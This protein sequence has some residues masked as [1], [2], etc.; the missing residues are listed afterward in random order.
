MMTLFNRQRQLLSLTVLLVGFCVLAG[1]NSDSKPVTSKTSKLEVASDDDE[2]SRS[3]STK[4]TSDPYSTGAPKAGSGDRPPIMPDA[5]KK[6]IEAQNPTNRNTAPSPPTNSGPNVAVNPNNGSG[7]A[8]NPTTGNPQKGP[9]S[10]PSTIPNV[11][12][13]N[14]NSSIVIP[15]TENATELVRFLERMM[16][17]V[18]QIDQSQQLTPDQK[19]AKIT[20]ALI[21]RKDAATKLMGLKDAT[22]QIR[23]NAVRHKIDSFRSLLENGHSESREEFRVFA[24]QLIIDESPQ[25]VEIGRISLVDL[26]FN[27][28]IVGDDKDAAPFFEKFRKLIKDYP[29]SPNV[30][31]IAQTM[32]TMMFQEN[33]RDIAIPSLKAL[34]ENY[35]GSP[36]KGIALAVESLKD[37][38]YLAEQEFD[39]S[40]NAVGAGEKGASKKLLEVCSKILKKDPISG[41]I[42]QQLIVAAQLLEGVHDYDRATQLYNEVQAR[43]AKHPNSELVGLSKTATTY[44]LKRISLLGKPITFEGKMMTG[45][46]FD[47]STY[48]DNVV[49]VAFWAISTQRS[50]MQLQMLDRFIG[51]NKDAPIK[52][53]AVNVDDDPSFLR[54]MFAQARQKPPWT[55]IMTNDP[56]KLGLKSPMAVRCGVD[57]VP[58]TLLIDQTGKVVDINIYGQD[59]ETK[60]SE[61]LG[62]PVNPT[63]PNQPSENLPVPVDPSKADPTKG[64]ADKGEADKG[65]DK[66]AAPKD[67][68]AAPE[69]AAPVKEPAKEASAEKK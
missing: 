57:S 50:F 1:C 46:D 56:T 55:N 41:D 40:L 34:I 47:W 6:Q 69:K 15:D 58:F 5:F 51:Q 31:V 27:S 43:F 35:A 19:M 68:K 9:P 24:T 61:L 32:V 37:Q 22:N 45:A 65:G 2:P 44:G 38:L 14:P 17:Q 64:E 7:A 52:L 20:E 30:Y 26:S 67:A 59:L 49:V 28:L 23:I 18:A 8:T 60:V 63:F 16:Y 10:I 3:T 39:V 11:G 12:Q 54:Q 13:L 48:K 21:A 29:D 53:L 33:K 25:L 36:N 42:M 62:K 66:K 4:K